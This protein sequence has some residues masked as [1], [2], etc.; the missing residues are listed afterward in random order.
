MHNED[1]AQLKSLGF[2]PGVPAHQFLNTG[3]SR[4]TAKTI[5]RALFSSYLNPVTVPLDLFPDDVE[6]HCPLPMVVELAQRLFTPYRLRDMSE[7]PIGCWEHPDWYLRG[8]LFKSPFDELTE[9][10]RMHALLKGCVEGGFED[11][12]V[13]L[14]RGTPSFDPDAPIEIRHERADPGPLQEPTA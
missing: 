14:V 4:V 1:E 9:T 12:V 5:R 8:Y 10:I 3:K 2:T 7:V 11:G 6:H 13:Q